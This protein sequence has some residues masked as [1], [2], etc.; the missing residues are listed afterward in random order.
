MG[1]DI[2]VP[3]GARINYRLVETG[4]LFAQRP[5]ARAISAVLPL[6][7]ISG[8]A[9]RLV[10]VDLRCIELDRVPR[11]RYHFVPFTLPGME[12]DSTLADRS[13]MVDLPL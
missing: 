3:P 10:V 5:R 7:V 6:D 11:G 1:A 12:P 13:C 4:A 2:T 8:F 9:Q